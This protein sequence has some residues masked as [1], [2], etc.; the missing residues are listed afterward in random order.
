MPAARDSVIKTDKGTITTHKGTRYAGEDQKSTSP[1]T[2]PP[3]DA[4]QEKK[5]K[6]PPRLAKTES[7][8]ASAQRTFGRIPYSACPE[9]VTESDLKKIQWRVESGCYRFTVDCAALKRLA[10]K[11][12]RYHFPLAHLYQRLEKELDNTA[13][14]RTIFIITDTG[15]LGRERGRQH[16]IRVHAPELGTYIVLPQNFASECSGAFAR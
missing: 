4:P 9:H 8:P 10:G 3:S 16:F 14:T 12:A 7:L 5:S 2:R 1:H 15:S 13:L 6:P 11:L